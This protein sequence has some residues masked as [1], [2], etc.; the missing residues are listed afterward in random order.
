LGIKRITSQVAPILV[1]DSQFGSLRL[2]REQ[3]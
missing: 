1:A 3:H 2:A